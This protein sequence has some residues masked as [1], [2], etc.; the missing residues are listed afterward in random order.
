M[1]KI[2]ISHLKENDMN[3]I[4]RLKQYIGKASF[5]SNSDRFSALE[6]IEEIDCEKALLIENIETAA[7]EWARYVEAD[8]APVTLIEHI[9]AAIA[10]SLTPNAGGKRSDD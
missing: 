1:K 2:A 4:E 5:S 3:S 6:C 10:K 9:T 7:E 8:C